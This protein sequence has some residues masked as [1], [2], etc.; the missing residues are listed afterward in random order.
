MEMVELTGYM[1][2]KIM[3]ILKEAAVMIVS[4]VTVVMMKF[5]QVQEHQVEKTLLQV[6]PEM[7]RLLGQMT[8]MFF[9]EVLA[10]IS[11]MQK[12]V[13]MRSKETKEPTKSNSEQAMIKPLEE[14]AMMISWVKPEMMILREKQAMT[15]LMVVLEMMTFTVELEMIQSKEVMIMMSFM[16]MMVRLL[17]VLMM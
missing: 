3:T 11:S 15:N 14:L 13:M 17:T 4:L 8:P 7:I 6:A 12:E 9:S 5:T 1:A 10:M 2:L 16:V